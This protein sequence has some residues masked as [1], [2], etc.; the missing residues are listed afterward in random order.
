MT[1]QP[2]TLSIII[3]FFSIIIIIIII[4]IITSWSARQRKQ[5][6]V[7]EKGSNPAP[8]SIMTNGDASSALDSGCVTALSTC[9]TP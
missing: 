9:S 8:T 4:I 2:Y 6:S 1:I 7:S 3:F 5:S